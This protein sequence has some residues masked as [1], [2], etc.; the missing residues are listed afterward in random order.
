M[1]SALIVHEVITI[2]IERERG[3]VSDRFLYSLV[4]GSKVKLEMDEEKPRR[5]TG[6]FLVAGTEL[7]LNHILVWIKGF[8]GVRILRTVS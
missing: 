5:K 8:A 1:R 2:V 4:T 6:V 3:G 7:R